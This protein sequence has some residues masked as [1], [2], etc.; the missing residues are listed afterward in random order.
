MGG[1]SPLRLGPE[2]GAPPSSPDVEPE[3]GLGVC[4]RRTSSQGGG[5][6][7]PRGQGGEPEVA[8]AALASV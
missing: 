8:W 7:E 6:G 4:M 2:P 1:D 5:R 3:V